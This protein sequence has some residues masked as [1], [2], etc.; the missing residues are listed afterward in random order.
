MSLNA[1][2]VHYLPFKY[3]LLD[4]AVKQNLGIIAMKIPSRGRIF[5]HDGITSMEQALRYV[6]SFPVSN[7]IVGIDNLKQ[8]EENVEITRNFQKYTEQQMHEVEQLTAHY[9][10]NGNWFKYDW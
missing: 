10:R 5:R 8:L 9:S 1:A 2:D 7:A 4:A 3:G 6:Y